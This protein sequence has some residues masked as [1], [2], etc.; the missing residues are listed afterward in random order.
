MPEAL[1]S[2]AQ[3]LLQWI[4]VATAFVHTLAAHCS[5]IP[6]ELVQE[7]DDPLVVGRV[8]RST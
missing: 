2:T 1:L 5:G 3:L 6:L 4:I 7:L 8:E